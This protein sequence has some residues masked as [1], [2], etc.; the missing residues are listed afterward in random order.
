MRL[1]L[2]ILVLAFIAGA[3]QAQIGAVVPNWAVPSSGFS[4]GSSSGPSS[5][6]RTL[7]DLGNPGV[8]VGVTPCRIVDTRGPAGPF[9][10]PSLPASTPRSFPLPSGPCTG[11]AVGVAGYSLNITVTNTLGPGFIAL[12][13]TGGS[14]PGVSTLN[15]LAGQTIANAAIVPAGSG[16]AITAVAGVS[17]TDLIIDINGYFL[18]SG[19]TINPGEFVGFSGAGAGV[20]GLV[21]SNNTSTSTNEGTS[22]FRGLMTGAGNGGAAILGEQ[23]TTSGVNYGA[24]GNNSSTTARSAGVLGVSGSRTPSRTTFFPTGVRGE[25]TGARN[26]VLGMI[27]DTGGGFAVAGFTF[28][29]SS[30]VLAGRLGDSGSNLGVSYVG[31]LGGSGPKAFYEPHPTDPD[32]VIRYVSLEGPEAG[33]YFRG[34]GV[35]EHGRAVID[36]PESFRMVTDAEG[37]TAQVTVMGRPTVIG[38]SS[39][40]LN[41]VVV[42]GSRDVEFS[43]LVQGVRRAYKD[44]QVVA[45]HPFFQPRSP[46]DQMPASLSPDEKARLIANGTYN[47]DGSVNMGTAERHGWAQ[48]WRDRARA[49]LERAAAEAAGT[50]GNAGNRR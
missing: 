4:S 28:A 20:L 21:F 30:I 37:L 8:F 45:N 14:A 18:N 5:G 19:T 12:Y 22:A 6:L 36:V 27:E 33:T 31:G 7:A 41:Q 32:K 49:E 46:D 35:L 38:V 26:G 2:V 40:D 29:S 43:Y 11:I 13:P 39:L 48:Q 24:R 15:Y 34:R 23:T 10:A 42:E 25:S 44:F 50:A 9:G 47:A 1:S 17:G 16:G 3:A